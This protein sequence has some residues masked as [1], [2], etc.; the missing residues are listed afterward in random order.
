MTDFLKE[1]FFEEIFLN[2]EEIDKI[3]KRLGRE[4][5]NDYKDKNLLLIS[6]LK[7]SVL[8]ISDLMKEIKLYNCE[9]D[10]M[11]MSSYTGTKNL[12]GE[13]NLVKDLNRDVT[14]Y[15]ILIVEDI[16]E[17]GYTLRKVVDLIKNKN[18]KSLKICTFL[19]KP[20][21][22]KTPIEADYVGITI[23]DKFVVGYGMDYYEKCRNLPFVGILNKKYI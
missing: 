21:R 19:D 1:D 3:V 2:E 13:V 10:F 7:G 16:L 9:V 20:I 11:C 18:P 5:T 14:D 8:F 22:R 6:V 15:D 4:I 17:S 12:G 23:P